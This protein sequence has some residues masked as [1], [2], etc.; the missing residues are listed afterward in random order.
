MSDCIS[1]IDTRADVNDIA[2][3]VNVSQMTNVIHT[4][5]VEILS[6]AKGY[7]EIEPFC[8]PGIDCR[9][10]GA[11][12]YHCCEKGAIDSWDHDV[13]CHVFQHGP[14]TCVKLDC[15]KL[16]P[17]Q[18]L[19]E[20]DVCWNDDPC[21]RLH[22]LR[23]CEMEWLKL[24]KKTSWS[25]RDSSGSTTFLSERRLQQLIAEAQSECDALTC[26]SNSR[27]VTYSCGGGYCG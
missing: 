19:G 3:W 25:F 22:Q 24:G 27:C 1:L 23:C 6:A 9:I 21:E 17:K 5:P 11:I 26:Q 10:V 8:V 16:S 13:I 14:D 7:L 12:I 4:E 20:P 18:V 2:K 15:W